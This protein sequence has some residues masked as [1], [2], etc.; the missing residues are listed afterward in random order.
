[1]IACSLG[2]SMKNWSSHVGLR[3]LCF[4]AYI[5][6]VYIALLFVH[7][8]AVATELRYTR[9][10]EG[11]I[12]HTT[13]AIW[14]HG[15]E[16]YIQILKTEAVHASR[17]R[18]L[19]HVFNSIPFYLT[20]L[21]NGDLFWHDSDVEWKDRIN[22]DLQTHS[23]FLLFCMSLSIA[24]IGWSGSRVLGFMFAIVFPLVFISA[25]RYLNENLLVNYC[26]SGEI[27]QLLFVCIYIFCMCEAVSGRRPSVV[28]ELAGAIALILAYAMKETTIVL[29]P[30]FL[31]ILSFQY[32]RFRKLSSPMRKFIVRHTVLHVFMATCMITLV[33]VFDSGEYVATRYNTGGNLVHNFSRSWQYMTIY[34]PIL[35]YLAV[36]LFL[37]VSIIMKS[38]T[39]KSL[40]SLEQLRMMVLLLT[41]LGL[42]AG[43]WA[44]NIPWDAQLCK[45]YLPTFFFGA[46]AVSA[47]L[48][49]SFRLFLHL[50]LYPAAI[51]WLLG[52][53]CFLL[54]KSPGIQKLSDGYY[55]NCY[56]HRKPIPAIVANIA[57]A[58][59]ST[60]KMYRVYI[61]A[62]KLYQE[63]PLPFLRWL[64]RFHHLNIASGGEVVSS[65]KAPERNYFRRYPGAQ[66]VEVTLGNSVPDNVSVDALY[67]LMPPREDQK[68]ILAERGYMAED[69]PLAATGRGT[70]VVW[71]YAKKK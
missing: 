3:G 28:R 57:D 58:S 46:L 1:M 55:R 20:V 43:F 48:L 5:I 64:N 65:V 17:L 16:G 21:R 13:H 44:I 11:N 26:D 38:S 59:A 69:V 45:Y 6:L 8:G 60:D 35:I 67:F 34:S 24:L 22:G 42:M 56:A 70:D 25:P 51:M 54:L 2:M 50:K 19:H 9:V 32:A 49:I 33:A 39:Y 52:S 71:R 18:P 29:F 63:G 31:F 4:I 68:K 10:A 7:R 23:Y 41:G 15:V 47:V 61:V 66:S 27:G 30:A 40:R 37:A 62:S 53:L 12:S 36:A 14:N